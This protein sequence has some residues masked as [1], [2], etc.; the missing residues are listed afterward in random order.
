MSMGLQPDHLWCLV[1][2]L[3]RVKNFPMAFREEVKARKIKDRKP[4]RE[5][6]I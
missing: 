4:A 2:H 6:A 1:Q 3:Q 5:A